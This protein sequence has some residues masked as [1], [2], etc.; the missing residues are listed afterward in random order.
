MN[1]EKKE[2]PKS[3]K[4]EAGGLLIPAGLFIGMGIG[5]AFDYLVQGM[6]IGLGA[7]FLAFAL[8]I[9]LKRD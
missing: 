2:K 8:V 9:L 5:W 3:R 6:F 1:E 4:T 7:G